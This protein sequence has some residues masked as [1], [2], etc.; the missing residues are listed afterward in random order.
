M[1]VVDNGTFM[2]AKHGNFV[3]ADTSD[4]KASTAFHTDQS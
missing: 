3:D 4:A 2:Y 1:N